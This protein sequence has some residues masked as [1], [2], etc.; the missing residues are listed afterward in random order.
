MSVAAI[1][2][3]NSN[4]QQQFRLNK[5]N[6]INDFF[7]DEIRERKLMGKKP[8]KYISAFDYFDK[9]LIVLFAASGSISTVSFPTV[10]GAPVRTT[11]GRLCLACSINVRLFKTLFKK[12]EI[13]TKIIII[14]WF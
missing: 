4:D 3:S 11:S 12:H 1:M 14:L 10:F 13:K 2:Y 5:I 8:S 7:I 9:S 6:K